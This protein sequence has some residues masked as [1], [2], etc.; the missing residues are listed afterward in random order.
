MGQRFWAEPLQRMLEEQPA[1][2]LSYG[3]WMDLVAFWQL[4]MTLMIHN[5]SLSV[6]STVS[7]YLQPASKK[8][9]CLEQFAAW[10]VDP[11]QLDGPLVHL[12]QLRTELQL[13]RLVDGEGGRDSSVGRHPLVYDLH[14]ETLES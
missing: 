14:L 12:A 10:I 13:A 2:D 3:Q 7:P 9:R 8:Q 1:S 4:A 11:R 5:D 6:A